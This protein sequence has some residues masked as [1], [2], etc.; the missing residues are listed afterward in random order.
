MKVLVTGAT[1]LLGSHLVPRLLEENLEVRILKQKEDST[2]LPKEIEVITGDIRDIDSVK[3][4]VKG[5]QAVFHLAGLISYWSKLNKLQYEINVL[6]TKNIVQACLENNAKLIHVSST[7]AVGIVKN[8]LADETIEYNLSPLKVNYCNTKFLAEQEILKKKVDA[9][10]VCPATMYGAK[11]KR[12]IQTDLTFS[13]KFPMNLFYINGGLAVVDVNDVVEGLIKAWKKGKRGERYLL[14]GENVTFYE[15]R[16]TVAEALNKKPPFICL[17]NWFLIILSYLFLFISIF[18]G[19]KPKLTPE[20]VRFN[21]LYFY[22]S[23]EKAKKEL[24]MEFRLFKESIKK[25]VDWY[26]ENGYL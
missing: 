20:M 11:D 8:G 10:I 21:K 7:A 17:P 6:G 4:A 26:K 2:E 1:G 23:N 15:I 12:K 19:K 13:F 5:C 9:V 14:V 24:G 3:K 16:K 18:T 22:F 25:A